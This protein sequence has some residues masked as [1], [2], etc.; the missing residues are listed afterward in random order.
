[1]S[2]GQ[3]PHASLNADGLQIARNASAPAET[4]QA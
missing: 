4:E 1:M 2:R 3:T